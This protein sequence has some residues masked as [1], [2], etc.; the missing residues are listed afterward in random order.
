MSPRKQHAYKPLGLKGRVWLTLGA[1]AL[2]GGGIVAV[3][4]AG[5][6]GPGKEPPRPAEVR[7]LPLEAGGA[8]R[9]GLDRREVE[10]FSMVSVSWAGAR[11]RL[12]GTA[13]VRTRSAG[14]GEWGDWQALA[15]SGGEG[16]DVPSERAGA[17]PRGSVGPLWVGPSDA[18]EVRVTAA[19]GT[20]SGLPKGMRLDMVDPGVPSGSGKTFA[21]APVAFSGTVADSAS[22]TAADTTAPTASADPAGPQPDGTATATDPAS[23]TAPESA[24]PTSS[25]SAGGSPSAEPS[26]TVPTAPPSTVAAPPVT[27]RAAWGANED[28]EDPPSYADGIKAVTLHHT[29]TGN[30]Y[31]CA[32]SRDLVRS[33]QALHMDPNGNGWNDIGYNFVVDKCGQIFEGRGGADLPVVGAHNVGFNTGTVGIAV[34]GNYEES[35]TPRPALD[36]VARIAAWRLGQYGA[37]P[38][39]TVALTNGVVVPGSK[40]A[41]DEQ[42]T[43]PRIF[44]HRDTFATAC[45]GALLYP[46]LGLIRSLAAAPGVSHA[47]DT[48]DIDRN[49]VND[50]VAGTPK[51]GSGSVTVLPGNGDGPVASAKRTLT[52]SSSGVPG[53]SESGDAFGASV[54]LGDVD[55]DGH[56]DVAIGAPGEDDTTGHADSGAVTVLYGPGLDT[57]KLFTTASA[58]RASGEKLGAAVTIGDFD[59]DGRADVLSVAPGAPGRWWVRDSATGAVTSGLLGSTGY[60]S[61]VAFPDTAAGDFDRDGYADAVVT[62]RDPG[63]R[64]RLLLLEGSPDGL[65][66][67]GVLGVPG[68]R[69]VAV[70]DVDGNGYADAVVGQPYASESGAYKGGQ[71]TVVPGSA[72]GLTTTGVRTVHQDTSGVPGAAEAGDAMGFSVAAGDFDLDGRADVLTGLPREDL[73]RSGTSRQDAG[74]VLLLRGSSSGPTGSGALSLHQDT[75]GIAGATETGD[76]FGSAVVLAD[77]SGWGRADLLVGVDGEDS[78]NGTLL[79]LDSGSAGISTTGGVYYGTGTLGLPAGVRLGQTLAP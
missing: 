41:Q 68:G 32:D 4:T 44:G 2:G 11:S 52:Q 16:P 23:P 72:T 19:D 49:G 43:L 31:T 71:V 29:A 77:L 34:I 28:L 36:A 45:P 26:A 48:A 1:V 27:G 33:L 64:S 18:V 67:T 60:D 24:S 73:T 59:A 62:F 9:S 79:Q 78:G 38:T 76:R 10:P 42:V 63:G 75:S 6:S 12:D 15:E 3:A 70:G 7:A 20:S 17:T 21:G 69:S 37:S 35:V 8:G 53:A 74:T 54:A 13:Q 46:K 56:A 30:D 61:A 14:T 58:T 47:L 22:P 57:G 65:R 55:G 40:Y 66:R 50:T 5:P 51:H 39:G 25:E